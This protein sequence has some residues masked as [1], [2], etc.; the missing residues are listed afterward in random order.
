MTL[1]ITGKKSKLSQ[2][3][4]TEDYLELIVTGLI[5]TF[6]LSIL[7]SI[8]VTQI[9]ISMIMACSIIQII[10]TK[11]FITT[12]LDKF[13]ILFILM[14]ALTIFLSEYP[15]S[16]Y[17]ILYIEIPFFI[18]YFALNQFPVIKSKTNAETILKILILGGI[19]A[20][21]YGGIC[22]AAGIKDRASAI[23]AGYYTTGIYLTAIATITLFL[24]K[25]NKIFIKKYIWFIVV[26]ILLAGIFLT[27][28]RVHWVIIAFAMLIVGVIKERKLLLIS[29]IL[30]A[31]AALIS[32]TISG[33]IQMLIHL[34]HNLSD[35]DIIWNYGLSLTGNHPYFGYGPRT[36]SKIF[37]IRDQLTDK[38]VD[39]W[40][41]DYLRVYLESGIVGLFAFISLIGYVIY[42]GYKILKK[43]ALKTE[44][45][46]LYRAIF[47]GICT[48]FLSSLAGAGVLDVLIIML[49]SLLLAIFTGIPENDKSSDNLP[50]Y[51]K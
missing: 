21:V 33:R 10:R 12:G 22:F 17:P 6:S 5:W 3:I 29:I 14:R 9:L 19:I 7:I 4:G 36:F 2:I 28:N 34:E 43:K 48:I 8:A 45:K 38:R 26:F 16:S 13:I 27:L 32:P 44:I 49:F 41:N 24:G 46:I 37:I 42:S 50:L 51:I 30:L 31:I 47:F 35:R 15:E 23:G 25:E 1:N 20:A 11:K 39:G 40:H 18:F